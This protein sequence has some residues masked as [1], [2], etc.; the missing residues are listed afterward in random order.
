M[1]IW[2]ETRVRGGYYLDN[3]M[4][5]YFFLY[6]ATVL[7]GKMF[8]MHLVGIGFACFISVIQTLKRGASTEFPEFLSHKR[9]ER[10]LN[11]QARNTAGD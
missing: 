10:A 5:E 9:P 3:F 11:A 7:N 6:K 1:E 4:S 8:L 2:N